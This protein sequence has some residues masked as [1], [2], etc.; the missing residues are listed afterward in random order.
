MIA[1]GSWTRITHDI[2]AYANATMRVRFGFSIAQSTG[3][4]TVSSWNIDDVQILSGP[5][6]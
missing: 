2:S 4:N 6:Q 5:C 1:D 3:L